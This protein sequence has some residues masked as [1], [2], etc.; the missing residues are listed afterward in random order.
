MN[1]RDRQ[2]IKAALDALHE[3]EG[4]ISDVP[5]HAEIKLRVSPPPMLGEYETA[6]NLADAMRLVIGV[7]AKFGKGRRWTITAEGSAARIEM[8]R[9]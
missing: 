1:A 6:M 9:E 7:P 4:Q 2:I 8:D 3:R 5:L